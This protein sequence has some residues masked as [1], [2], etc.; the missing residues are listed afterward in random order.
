MFFTSGTGV[1]S[2]TWAD[3][4]TAMGMSSRLMANTPACTQLTKLTRFIEN[5]LLR[6]DLSANAAFRAFFYESSKRRADFFTAEGK[7]ITR[8]CQ[9][10]SSHDQ[11]L[12]LHLR[13][14][15]SPQTER[16]MA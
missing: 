16:T 1:L 14:R 12:S 6:A 13:M 2:C 7:G 9:V 5:L 11:R 4:G 10:F 8:S 15:Q 3:V